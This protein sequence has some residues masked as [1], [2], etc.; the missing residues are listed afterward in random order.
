MEADLAPMALS[1]APVIACE[2]NRVPVKT[3]VSP[4]SVWEARFT[5]SLPQKPRLPRRR[6]SQRQH[7][8]ASRNTCT[9]SAILGLILGFQAIFS[10]GGCSKRLDRP[11]PGQKLCN[12]STNM[13]I[14]I[15]KSATRVRVFD[16]GLRHNLL[17]NGVTHRNAVAER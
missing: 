14:P 9:D 1:R 15:P 10:T 11:T 4:A 7:F 13:L 6:H 12:V 17:G 8:L 2:V 3:K 16:S 5:T